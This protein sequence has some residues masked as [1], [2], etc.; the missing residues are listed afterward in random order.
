MQTIW[1]PRLLLEGR[2]TG[3][4]T[5]VVDGGR[6]VDVVPGHPGASN[7]RLALPHGI[8]TPGMVDLQLNGMYGVDL[9]D[10]DDADWHEVLHRLPSTGVTAFQPTV[11]TAPLDALAGALS[12]AR[13][14]RARLGGTGARILGVHAEGPFLSP[15]RAG[16]HPAHLMLDPTP[17]RLDALLDTGAG[18]LSMVTLAPERPGGMAA[19]RHL[20]ERGVR[21]SVGHTDAT[22]AQVREA[23]DAG[24]GM[25]THVFN[26]QRPLGHRE[27][28]VPGQALADPRLTVGLIADLQHVA[29]EVC[30][31][32]MQAAPG[33]VALV[34][35]AVA[36]AAMPPGRYRLG[37]VEVVVA[38]Q[39]AVPRR[40]DGTIAGSVLTLDAAVRNLVAIG[41]DAATVLDAAAAV[42]ARVLGRP[43]LGRLATGAAA[44]LVWWS[45]DLHP[46]CTW[47][48]GTSVWAA[49]ETGPRPGSAAP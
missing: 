40:T 27:P 35:D 39:G 1:A 9:A 13:T 12:R 20:V 4:G 49:E 6:I 10:A 8:L 24:A 43:D 29:P 14:A 17:E 19:V 25:V 34:T 21:V 46:L 41:V 23:A 44:D 47:I 28:G 15:D 30:T 22:A 31:V 45:D 32:V 2:L 5:V 11:I 18:I 7:G 37:G 42:P 26:A 48:D 16:M 36:A 3:P 33:R 38:E